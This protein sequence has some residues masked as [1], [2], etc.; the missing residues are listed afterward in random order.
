MCVK[1]LTGTLGNILWLLLPLQK[2][3]QDFSILACQSCHCFTT[4]SLIVPAGFLLPFL[5]PGL[6]YEQRLL[7]WALQRLATCWLSWYS[8]LHHGFGGK[9]NVP[10]RWHLGALQIRS[11]VLLCLSL[12]V[13]TVSLAP[14]MFS[15][16]YFTEWQWNRVHRSLIYFKVLLQLQTFLVAFIYSFVLFG[17]CVT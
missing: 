9:S 17:T 2:L 16:L 14:Q 7:G 1:G 3:P 5:Q 13:P 15:W 12:V 10:S 4:C 8:A 11:L 6:K